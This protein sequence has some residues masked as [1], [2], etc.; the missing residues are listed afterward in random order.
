[1]TKKAIERDL[2]WNG[3]CNDTTWL[4]YVDGR[5]EPASGTGRRMV[6]TQDSVLSRRPLLFV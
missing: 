2:K 4:V 5:D 1:M 3:K 6:S